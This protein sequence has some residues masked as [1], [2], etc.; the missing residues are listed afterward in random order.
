MTQITLPAPIGGWNAR[1]DISQIRPDQA[2]VLENWFP[3]EQAVTT[4]PGHTLYAEISGTVESLVTFNYDT[5]EHLLA[6]NGGAILKIDQGATTELKTGFT[7]NRWNAETISGYAVLFNGADTPQKYDGSS[8]TDNTITGSGLSASEL[9][10]PWKFKSRLFAVQ[11]N[12]T[13]AWYLATNAIAGTASELDFSS[14]AEGYL[15]AGGT[16]TRDGGAGAD[17]FCVFLFSEG[18]VLIYQGDNPSNA[19]SWA[20]VGAFKIGRPLGDRPLTSFGGE[21]L[22]ITIDGL[23]PLSSMLPSGR[24]NSQAVLTDIV[25]GAWK[26]RA[27]SYKDQ[28]GWQAMIYPLAQ[29]GI[30]NVPIGSARYEQFVINTSTGAWC[31]F[32]G[33]NA[34]CW[35]LHRDNAFFSATGGVYRF[36]N[37]VSDNGMT[38]TGL[39]AA[40]FLNHA[41]TGQKKAYKMV[42]PLMSSAGNIPVYIGF[43]TD[44]AAKTSYYEPTAVETGGGA[45]WD[46]SAW[47]ADEW[48]GAQAPQQQ[49]RNVAG[50]GVSGSIRMKTIT[51][52]NQ[53]SLHGIDLIYVPGNGL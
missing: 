49:W 17:D 7:N 3:G 51:R 26:A 53:V 25:S 48:A 41:P 40:P 36:D 28:N 52:L 19:S 18:D 9:I 37:G 20:L 39:Y 5:T 12:S 43:D 4:R 34:T 13:S 44:Y 50:I 2:I 11:K 6:G 32:T 47:D 1:D 21:L 42:R 46:T 45:E 8:I 14:L 24:S 35:A 15:V 22:V 30:I 10:Y 16:W 33:I 38:I 27:R 23:V 31:R 29:M